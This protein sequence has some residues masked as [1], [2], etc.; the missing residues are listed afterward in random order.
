MR[1]NNNII[2]RR[3]R[4]DKPI[5]LWVPTP[6]AHEWFIEMAAING[7][8]GLW[9]DSQHQNY[10]DDQLAH[11]CLACRAGGIEPIIRVR[12]RDAGSYSRAF[13]VGGTGIIVPH[14]NTAA[15]ARAIVRECKFPPVGNRG[16]DGVEPAAKFGYV[17][18]PDYVK[19]ANEETCIVVQI[20]E[21]EAVEN[22]EEIAA[23]KGIDVLM[24]G[25]ADLTLRYD[26]LGQ[27]TESGPWAAVERVAAAAKKNGIQWGLPVG[28][29]ELARKYMDMGARYFAHGSVYGFCLDGFERVRKTMGPLFEMEVQAAHASRRGY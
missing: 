20:E 11:M 16:L 19:Q 3:F 18:G 28:S 12:K 13:E 10:S 2:L 15:E 9:I 25:P 17:P 27:I 26:C 5:L 7:Y 14:V 4:E 21:R 1:V 24:I 23:V 8:H 22:V 29:V 6:V